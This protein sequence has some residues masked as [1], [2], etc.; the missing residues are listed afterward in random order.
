MPSETAWAPR[1]RRAGAEAGIALIT[2]IMVMMLVS[3]VMVGFVAAIIA[4]NRAS[5]LDHDQTQAYAAAHA[6]LEK[7]TS[8]MSGLFLADFSPSPTQINALLA[9]RPTI[10]GFQ[11]LDPDGS[12]GYRVTWDF[13]DAFGNPA[14]DPS[15]TGTITHGP[16]QGFKGLITP[17]NITVT[18][19]SNG[20]AEVRMKR[21]LQTI[22]VPVFQF[23]MFSETD[24]SFHAGSNF[25][26]GGRV[27]TNGNLYL[28][29]GNGNTLTLSDRIT[30]VG[31]VIRTNLSNGWLTSSN[32]T[33][34]VNVPTTIMANP[35]NNINRALARTEG[36]LVGTVGSAAMV[37]P[38]SWTT[39][40]VGTYHSNIRNGLTGAKRLDLP[41]VSQGAV[42]VD[43]IRRPAQ[44]SAENTA[45]P[46][47]YQQRYFSQAALR[48]L[49]SDTAADITN[50]PTVVTAT[51]PVALDG[52]TAVAAGVY[53]PVGTAIPNAG[54][55]IPPMAASPGPASTTLTAAAAA[56][57]NISVAA[58]L[59]FDPIL[60]VG[61]TT[62]TC[63]G[64][65]AST[66][67]GCTGTP[68]AAAGTAVTSAG[69]AATA[70]TGVTLA[71]AAIINVTANSTTPFVPLAFWA[72]A[73]NH[74]CTGYTAT[75]F[76][77][78]TG[79]AI[80]NGSTITTAALSSA[81]QPR[82]NG[83]I[84]IEK[85][86]SAGAWSDVT[87][88]I[89]NLGIAATNQTGTICADP[90]PNAIIRLQR[91]RDNGGICN[92]A[93]SL[94]ATDYWPNALY[95]TREGIRRDLVTTDTTIALGGVMD[96]VALDVNNLRKWFAGT[97]GT[98]GGQA[99]ND[100]GY[101]VY[102]SDR[103]NNRNP[104]AAQCINGLAA[105]CESG[106]YGFED[107]V[108]PADA[109]G[110]PNGGVNQ[111]V[112]PGPEAGEDTG[113]LDANGK[114]VTNLNGLGNGVLEVYGATPQNLPAGA[115]APYSAAARPWL[116][117]VGGVAI[118]AAHAMV[119][120]QILFRRALKLVN[121]GQGQ[122]P[123]GFTVT[124]ENPA[125]V[126]GN[127]NATA[128]IV[129]TEAHVPA[130]IIADA[131][132]FLSTAWSDAQSFKAP[133]D[134]AGRAAVTTGYRVAIIA[135]KNLAFTRPTAFTPY[136]DFGTDGGAHNFLRYLESWSGQTLNYRGSIVSFYFSR[137]ATGVYKYSAGGQNVYS[138]PS[139][140][141]NFDT[142]FLVPA[143]LP[144]GTPMFRDI[145]T[146]TFR[147]LLR[148]NQ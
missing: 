53:G 86:S 3:V 109:N 58:T 34:T 11:F 52:P 80:A 5:G 47:I 139:R 19:R 64:K 105:P 146:L 2:V 7:L 51:A 71:N 98:T 117:T 70:T 89:L 24:L 41:L 59:A 110:V 128:A 78:C 65:T 83:F 107:V 45:A 120:R 114:P 36:S 31:E 123:P 37:G 143:L 73:N 101:I 49:L 116:T 17:Y 25:N 15:F 121:G 115:A 96:Y 129:A 106:E 100:N 111:A 124:S 32:Y 82:L 127:Y 147:Q 94:K 10:S 131:V 97:I 142:D 42:P 126:Q 43:L 122:L 140:G 67:T 91:L 138:P 102:F 60:L 130:A 75:Q 63:S 93:G 35:V 48:I 72:G 14:P 141:Y 55:T 22:A 99:K 30:A 76:T 144:P 54:G 29:E 125:Y 8:D 50:L 23:G 18:A 44:N 135:G 74:S 92:Y 77:G 69:G 56:N 134:A 104:T 108:N 87:T 79:A 28:A 12:S 112:A 21:T 13:T 90:N 38:P 61:A 137:Q 81:G 136:Q 46:L 27:H 26:F 103:R 119:N 118:T 4:D 148:P 85:Q 132:T 145:N 6:G 57:A 1:P 40:S 84:K 33:G 113:G 88:E 68:A 9:N 39:L 20:G 133:N 66:F 16:Y 95:D 62:V